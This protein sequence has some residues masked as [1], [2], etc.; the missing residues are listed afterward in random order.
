MQADKVCSKCKV[1]K[2]ASA[3]GIRRDRPND[4][5]R[6]RCIECERAH[7]ALYREKNREKV[8]AA[9]A[10]R[11]EEK[12]DAVREA[13]A[14]YL[15][16]N[17]DLVRAQEK[18]RRAENR[19]ALL[20]RA[21]ELY[22]ENR[23][24]VLARK[25]EWRKENAEQARRAQNTLRRGNPKYMELNRK[26]CKKRRSTSKGKLENA[27][28]SR[29]YKE[30]VVGS[31]KGWKTFDLLGYDALD[32][33]NH[34]EKQFQPG[35]SWENYGYS[36]WHVDHIIPLA[37]FKYTTPDCQ[38]FKIAWGLSNLQPLWA[39]DNFAKGS[40]MPANHVSMGAL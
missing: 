25:A 12:P 11:R 20:Q 40:K 30:I 27:V 17:K 35:M 7:S 36:G 6:P 31:K 29:I 19:E 37:S 8:N 34:I 32:L 16:N 2:P 26:Q 38:D 18:K 3:F 39:N 13:S 21:R 4:Q 1:L 10:R 9:A 33:R 24:H 14:R 28:R 5:L 22:A 23:D 15:A